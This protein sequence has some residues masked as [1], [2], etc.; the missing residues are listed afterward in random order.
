MRKRKKQ[1]FKI[2]FSANVLKTVLDNI[3]LGRFSD[4]KI[5]DNAILLP[6]KQIQIYVS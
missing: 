6:N 3:R 4:L 2:Q 1:I 5:R